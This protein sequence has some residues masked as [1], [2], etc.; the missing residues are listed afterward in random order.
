MKIMM[1]CDYP[2]AASDITG[3]VAAA[4]YNLV[5]ALLKNTSAEIVVI[6]FWH[7]YT[8]N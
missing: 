1:I 5:H 4:A 8:E 2:M 7:D 6:G 3:G